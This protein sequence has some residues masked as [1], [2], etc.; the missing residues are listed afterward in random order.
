MVEMREDG[1]DVAKDTLSIYGI[2]DGSDV[3]TAILSNEAHTLPKNFDNIVDYSGSG[4]TIQ[5]YQG[6]T[7]LDVGSSVS[8]GFYTITAVGNNIQ[9]NQ[10]TTTLNEFDN[11]S[12]LTADAASITFT[13]VGKDSDGKDFSIVKTQTF[14]ISAQGIRGN[15]G[16]GITFRGV[17]DPTEE[18]YI[19]AV[20]GGNRGDVVEYNG[21]Y[22]LCIQDNGAKS[23]LQQKDPTDGAYWEGFGAEFSSVATDILLAKDAAITRS[24]VMGKNTKDPSGSGGVIRSANKTGFGDGN[25]GFFLGDTDVVEF[26][27]GDSDSLLLYRF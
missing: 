8:A 4:T 26:E 11:A 7:E 5:V 25:K 22:Y 16:V 9:A 2:Q 21:S 15:R 18:E 1:I 12:N 10:S 24:L 19:G 13:I 3:I 20:D 6:T 27:V 23:T 14:S 17:Y